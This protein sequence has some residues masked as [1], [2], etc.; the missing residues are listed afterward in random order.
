[1]VE[2]V[3]FSYSLMHVLFHFY[4]PWK[5]KEIGV[6]YVHHYNLWIVYFKPALWSSKILTVNPGKLSEILKQYPVISW[7][8]YQNYNSVWWM[9]SCR[10][11]IFISWISVVQTSHHS[12]NCKSELCHAGLGLVPQHIISIQ[13]SEFKTVLS[14]NWMKFSR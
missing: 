14:S 8:T 7:L 4:L 13:V 9:F 2:K 12:L 10:N 1:M 11:S 5:P 6:Q 3:F